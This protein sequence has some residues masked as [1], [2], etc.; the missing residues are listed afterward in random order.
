MKR[1]GYGAGYRYDHGERD[2]LAAGQEYLPD[3]LRGVK[4]Y[5]PTE[6]GYEQTIRERLERWEEIR[7]EVAAG[8]QQSS[9]GE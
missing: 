2:A 6:R 9:A 8:T 5:Q 4:W 1:L 3:A 7:R